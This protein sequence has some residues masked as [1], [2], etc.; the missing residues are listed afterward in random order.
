LD[1]IT[2][3]KPQPMLPTWTAAN[4]DIT[5]ILDN[6][7]AGKVA[8]TVASVQINDIINNAIRGARKP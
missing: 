6:V 4:N 1:E 5:R 2:Y 3:A 8:T 7:R